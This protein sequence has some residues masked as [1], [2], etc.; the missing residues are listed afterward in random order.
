MKRARFFSNSFKV[1]A[2][3]SGQ[4]ASEWA[5]SYSSRA[6]SISPRLALAQHRQRLGQR[7]TERGK[8]V[9]HAKE[10]GCVRCPPDEAVTLEPTSRSGWRVIPLVLASR[11]SVCVADIPMRSCTGRQCR[12]RLYTHNVR[13]SGAYDIVTGDIEMPS[14]RASKPFRDVLASAAA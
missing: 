1:I 9:V 11:T 13:R 3:E 4:A 12:S 10:D 5:A 8:L 2:G 14:G 7:A 6:V